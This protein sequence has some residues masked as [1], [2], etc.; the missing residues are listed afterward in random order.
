MT[1]ERPNRYL[2][3]GGRRQLSPEE[4]RLIDLA[5]ERLGPVLRLQEL[6]AALPAKPG[7]SPA[8][9]TR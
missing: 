3:R 6:K 2:R 8:S 5:L 7:A 4:S 1:Q 9:P